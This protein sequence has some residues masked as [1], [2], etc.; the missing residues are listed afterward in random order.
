MKGVVGRNKERNHALRE[1]LAELKTAF[2]EYK[3]LSFWEILGS[4]LERYLPGGDPTENQAAML[5]ASLR[6][7]QGEFQRRLHGQD[8]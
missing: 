4:Q 7:V 2:S 3:E 8:F 5:Q 6:L 1:L